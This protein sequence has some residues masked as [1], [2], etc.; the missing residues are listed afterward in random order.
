MVICAVKH[1]GSIVLYAFRF[2][3]GEMD[4][5][6]WETRRQKNKWLS[7]FADFTQLQDTIQKATPHDAERNV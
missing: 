1:H 7:A 6:I 5:W 3:A 2:G 4:G